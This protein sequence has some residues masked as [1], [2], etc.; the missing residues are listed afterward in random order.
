[1]TSLTE[2]FDGPTQIPIT[3]LEYPPPASVGLDS[4]HLCPSLKNYLEQ[5]ATTLA[6]NS[7]E[8][9]LSS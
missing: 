5:Q 4:S 9:I 8:I 1:M 6:R 3:R 2:P 7:L